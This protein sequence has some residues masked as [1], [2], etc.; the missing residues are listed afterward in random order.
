MKKKQRQIISAVMG[1]VFAVLA[2]YGYYYLNKPV[3]PSVGED[4]KIAG[5]YSLLGIMSLEKPYIC[6]FAKKDE[7]SSVLGTLHING[8][9]VYGDFR[10]QTQSLL[11][12]R[13]FR[14][15]LVVKGKDAYMWTSLASVGYKSKAAK[16]AFANA[17]PAE[18]AQ[19]VGLRDRLP[20][21]CRPWENPD[22]SYFEIPSGVNFAGQ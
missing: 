19:I 20:Y 8:K 3:K 17:S 12:G 11:E 15:F 6:T 13:P 21:E 1:I 16:S 4:G 22:P 2:G 10:I 18:Q 7:T 5:N 9:N 14:S